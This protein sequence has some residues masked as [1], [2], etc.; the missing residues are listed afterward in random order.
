MGQI[1][2]SI[3]KLIFFYFLKIVSQNYLSYL[4]HLSSFYFSSFFVRFIGYLL[5][6]Y[7]TDDGT[8]RDRYCYIYWFT[9]SPRRGDAATGTEM[10][11]GI[12]V[13]PVHRRRGRIYS[14]IFNCLNIPFGDTVCGLCGVGQ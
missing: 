14:I 5:F 7:G 10:P 13:P 2:G 12:A 11:T 4:S 6:C 3:Y 9:F 8:D 1:R